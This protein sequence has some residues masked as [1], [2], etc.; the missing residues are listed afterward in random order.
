[1]VDVVSPRTMPSDTDVHV[2]RSFLTKI[3]RSS[4][5]KNRFKGKNDPGGRPHSWH[6]SKL[7]E[8]ESESA[9]REAT[10]APVWQPKHEEKPKESS[11][12]GDQNAPRQL[13]SQFSSARTMERLERPPH[14]HPPGRYSPTKYINS[15]EPLCGPAA[16]RHSGLS[17]FSSTSSPPVPDPSTSDRKGTSAE[18]IFFKGPQSA[19]PQQAERPRYLQPTL[20]NGA[21]EGPRGEDQP[22]SRVSVSGRPS[23]SPVWQVPE[24]KKSQSPPPPP[25][26]PLRSD[27]YA[28]TK[29]FPYSEGPGDPAK[30]HSRSISKPADNNDQKGLRSHQEKTSTGRHNFTPLPTKDFLHPNTAAINNQNHNQ[31]HPNKL[32]SLSSNDV[33]QPHHTQLPAHQRQ[34][35]DESPLYPQTRSAPPTKIQ[36]VGSYYRSLQ[37]LPTNTFSRKHVR[38]S[39]ASMASSAANP[40]LENGWHNRYYG[41]ANRHSVQTA[42]LQARQGK[43]EGRREEIEKPHWGNSNEPSFPSTLKTNNKAKYSLPQSQLPYSENKELHSHQ[44]KGLHYEPKTSELSV[45]SRS[46]ADAAKRDEGHANDVK[47]QFPTHQSNDHKVNLS[48]HQGPWMPQEDQR[49]SPLKTPLLHSLAQESRSLAVRQPAATAVGVMSTQDASDAMAASSGK[50]N[51]RGDRYATFLRNEIQQKRAQLQKS[52]SAATLMCD[53]EDE[54]SEEWRSR[55]TSGV[56][57]S[58]TYKDHLKEAQARVLQATSFQRRDLEPLGPE[59]AVVKTTTGRVRGR[60]R[61]PLA[62]RMH[63]FSEPDKI[64][65]VGME[66][67]PKNGSFGERRNFFETKPAFPRPVLKSSQGTNLNPDPGEIGKPKERTPSGDPEEAHSAADPKPLGPGHEQVLLEQQRLGT[68]AE[69]Q[70]TWSKQKKS[71]EAKT[72]GRFHSAENILDADAKETAVCIH[73]RSRSSPSADFYTQNIPSLWKDPH[74]QQ[75]SYRGKTE[76]KLRYQPNH[77]PQS[78]PSV[79]R[80]QGL[81]P[82]LADH[83]TKPDAANPSH[84]THSSGPRSLSPNA[85]SQHPSQLPQTKGLLPPPRPHLGPETTSSPQEFLAGAQAGPAAL[86]PLSSCSSDTQ[87]HATPQDSSAGPA[88]ASSLH[89]GRASGADVSGEGG[90]CEVE[91]EKEQP[92]PPSSSSLFSS[93][94][95]ALFL[96]ATDRARPPSPQFV[97]LRLTDRPP[98]V[99]VQDDSTLRSEED[100]TPPAEMDV[101]SPVR[102]VPVRIVHSE[103]S[104]EREGR[105]HLTC[106]AFQPPA[107]TPT[108]GGPASSL[109]STYTRQAPQA[110]SQALVP[111]SVP[112]SSSEEDAK[113]E[114]LARDIMDKDKSLV[115]ILDQSSRRTTMDLMEGL[116]PTEEQILEG[117]HQRRRA[118]CGSRLPT[119]S[120]RSMD[121]R[122]EEDLSASAAA[123]LVPSSSYYNTS[124]PKAELLIK[125]KDMQDQQLEEPDSEDELDVDLASKKQELISSLARK[126]EVLR[127]ARQSLQDDV[128]DNEALGREVEATVQRLC[129]PNQLDKFCMFV[130]DLDKVV[131]LLLSLSGRLA[132]VE[133]ALNTL[134]DEASPEEKRTLTEKRKLLMQQHE[135][136]KELK[137]N[138]DRREQLVSGIMEAHLDPESLDDYRHFVKMKSALIIEQRKLEDKIKLGEEQLKCLVDSLP[139]EQRPLL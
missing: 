10:S 128:E 2:A 135:D 67:E 19:G 119:S 55:K 81:V 125:M 62:K 104:S 4:M 31:L 124:A 65:K 89:L 99:F 92:R 15:A 32:F 64:D 37:D 116:F 54:E 35:S 3:L 74:S 91:K 23:I 97:P 25:P 8:E 123:S 69:Y 24:K 20:G 136:A 76:S 98:A 132:R 133:N 110:P 88:P 112:E 134:E 36:S 126:L 12:Q 13:A 79:P 39:T 1:M 50:S 46:P 83:R 121:R 80:N 58:N 14:A 43:P 56:S 129:Q 16:R 130:G 122:E 105:A 96:P 120:P 102:K 138:L 106:S 90:E 27:S 28:A 114:E 77:S 53:A 18:S 118:S 61:F 109:F 40:N 42:A 115:D 57:S 85:G 84:T 60:K 100:L 95:A 51:R 68:F 22:A 6:S 66:G 59:A 93:W 111:D 7:T 127:D 78:A 11:N 107:R 70:A 30:S 103:S 17:C 49:I 117:A 108:T 75:S 48:R 9:R 139:L 52:R 82:G 86:Q 71:S 87:H 38:H 73:E 29:V 113:R 34:Y 101:N 137:E 72:Q 44:G 21:R 47:R 33:R 5:R 45:Q 41:L 94:T 63:S 131:S 26:P